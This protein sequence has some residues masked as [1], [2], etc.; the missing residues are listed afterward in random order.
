MQLAHS[1]RTLYASSRC[2]P[3]LADRHTAGLQAAPRTA[4]AAYWAT[5]A[6]ALPVRR[7]QEALENGTSRDAPCLHEAVGAR[8][9]A[10][11]GGLASLPHMD[12]KCERRE[13]STHTPPRAHAAARPAMP[14]SSQSSQAGPHAGAWLAAIPTEPATTLPPPAMQ[15]A[16]RRRLH[17]PAT[18][19]AFAQQHALAD[20]PMAA[21]GQVTASATTHSRA[22]AQDSS[23]GAK[24]V[25]RAW[26]RVVREAVGSEGQVVPQQW[27]AHSTAPHVGTQGPR[28]VRGTI[29]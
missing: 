22:R 29:P 9:L 4:P 7:C 23:P 15:I 24:I 8:E 10:A 1:L 25:E 20:R 2:A 13:S 21:E 26:V 18:T 19:S 11:T 5:W 17:S 12:G 28:R 3:R 6:D 16:L 14:P 27:L